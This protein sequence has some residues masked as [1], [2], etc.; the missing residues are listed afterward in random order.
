MISYY[1]VILYKYYNI[2]HLMILISYDIKAML[3]YI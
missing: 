2:I 1:H 3:K